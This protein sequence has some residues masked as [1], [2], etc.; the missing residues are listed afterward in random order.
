MEGGRIQHQ[1]HVAPARGDTV[2]RDPDR[3]RH[4]QVAALPAGGGEAD[5]PVEGIHARVV[6]PGLDEP[7]AVVARAAVDLAHELDVVGV[8]YTPRLADLLPRVGDAKRFRT[9][10]QGRASAS[11]S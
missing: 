9:F 3:L 4:G 2:P 11:P 5:V 10:L 8:R 1:V 6:D 7:D